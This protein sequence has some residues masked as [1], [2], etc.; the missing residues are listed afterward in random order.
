MSKIPPKAPPPSPTVSEDSP[1]IK[2][3]SPPTETPSPTSPA[4]ADQ[5]VFESKA[6]APT[7]AGLAPSP[8]DAAFSEPGSSAPASMD[9]DLIPDPPEEFFDALETLQQIQDLE[10]ADAIPEPPEEFFDA[11][12]TLDTELFTF[13]DARMSRADIKQTIKIVEDMETVLIHALERHIKQQDIPGGASRK[14]NAS[15]RRRT[16][17]GPDGTSRTMDFRSPKDNIESVKER[18]F[19]KR[20]RQALQRLA[21]ALPEVT[22]TKDLSTKTGGFQSEILQALSD[23]PIEIYQVR[24]LL[25]IQETGSL[26]PSKPG[27]KQKPKATLTR[28]TSPM[29]IDKARQAGVFED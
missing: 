6:T 13:G 22:N 17:P 21:A 8:H 14:S 23:P 5:S 25:P 2:Q 10:R 3:T 15:R 9:E 7:P 19:S 16:I 4:H 12:Q 11:L 27:S 28:V 20:E 18:Y 29:L 24:N 26:V 1:N